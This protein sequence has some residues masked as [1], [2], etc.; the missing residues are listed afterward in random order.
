MLATVGKGAQGLDRFPHAQVDQYLQ[1]VKRTKFGGVADIALQ[2]PHEARRSVRQRV[3]RFQAG[4]EVGHG[5][6]VQ[7]R[8][9]PGHVDLSKMETS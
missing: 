6:I 2:P 3:D 7:R 5:R 9:H 8:S 1:V 4:H